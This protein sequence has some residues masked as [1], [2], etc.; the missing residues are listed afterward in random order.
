MES[1]TLTSKTMYT[2]NKSE[3]KSKNRYYN[4]ILNSKSEMK[5]KK[6]R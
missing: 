3:N 4:T 5:A 2:G 6:R 1:K